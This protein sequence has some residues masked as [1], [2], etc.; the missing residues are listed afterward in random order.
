M[1]GR[2]EVLGQP[3][4]DPRSLPATLERESWLHGGLELQRP[5]GTRLHQLL[6]GHL[7]RPLK[8]HDS[9]QNF[10]AYT[11]ALLSPDFQVFLIEHDWAQAL[12]GANNY[13]HSKYD[14]RPCRAQ[15]Q[16]A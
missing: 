9:D 8:A 7:A 2:F 6:G 3:D 4:N 14:I 13:T 1:S 12:E 10:D 16:P 5:S 11:A 15:L